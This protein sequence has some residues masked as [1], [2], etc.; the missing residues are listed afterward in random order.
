MSRIFVFFQVCALAVLAF[1]PSVSHAAGQPL[2][3]V[4]PI[5][6]QMATVG[7]AYNY[8]I[9]EDTFS[10][11]YGTYAQEYDA[12]LSPSGDPLPAWLALSLGGTFSGTPQTGDVAVLE[13]EVHA[14]TESCYGQGSGTFTLT[15]SAASGGG[16]SGSS[17]IVTDQSRFRVRKYFGEGV[18]SASGGTTDPVDDGEGD[19]EEPVVGA[20][21]MWGIGG[22]KFGILAIGSPWDDP[23]LGEAAVLTPAVMDGMGSAVFNKVSIGYMQGCGIDGAGA[24][25]CWGANVE[26]ALGLGGDATWYGVPM[27]VVG[28][29]TFA[30]IG[31]ADNSNNACALDTSGVAWCWGSNSYGQLGDGSGAESST[32]VQAQSGATRF[33]KL[34]V[35]TGGTCALDSSGAMWCWGRYGSG[36]TDVPAAYGVG[37]SF[38]DISGHHVHGCGVKTDGSIWCW[39]QNSNGQLGDGGYVDAEN[40]VAVSGG[41]AFASVSVGQDHTCALAAGGV[42]YCWGSNWSNQLGIGDGAVVGYD[43][44]TPAAVLGG[45]S[46]SK[47]V[48]GD[49]R[50]C[51]LKSNGSLW[52]WGDGFASAGEPEAVIMPEGKIFGSV[53]VSSG[54]VNL[55]GNPGAPPSI[56]GTPT[57]ELSISPASVTGMNVVSPAE[58]GSYATFTVENVGA[59]ASP[60][61]ATTLSNTTSFEFG[62]NACSGQTLAIGGTCNMT[63]RPKATTNGGL[64]GTLT[65]SASG[66]AP[67]SATLSGTASGFA[68]A[69]TVVAW[70]YNGDGEL[71]DGTYDNQL[72][73]V[74]MLNVD[75]SA[76]WTGV[77][78]ISDSTAGYVCSR[79]NN[80][81]VWCWGYN[82]AGM[83]GP[84]DIDGYVKPFEMTSFGTVTSL[85]ANGHICAV[86]TDGTVWCL[87]YNDYGEL[88]D[89]TTDFSETAVQVSGLTGASQVV[90]GFYYTCALK[91]DGT[92]WCLGQ[93]DGQGYLGDGSG[94][95]SLVP[96]QVAGEGGVGYLTNVTQI[97]ASAQ[98]TCAVRSDGTVWCWGNSLFGWDLFPV[99]VSGEGGVGFLTGAVEVAAG[100]QHTC[101]RKSDGTVWCWG[102]NES[103]QLGDG[104]VNN[105]ATPVQVLDETGGGVLSNVIAIEARGFNSC[106]VRSDYSVWCWGDNND[107]SLGNGES[108]VSSSLPVRVIGINGAG[109]LEARDVF[110]G[111][112][113]GY[114]LQ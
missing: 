54:V 99:Q 62:A 108:G 57:A 63:V 34:A 74:Q 23:N 102:H 37:H 7:Q 1:C 3:Y 64:S 81:S 18:S 31:V 59:A 70:G 66:I 69:D 103:G 21:T 105:S 95:S 80:G 27:P 47:I 111:W 114:A 72:D 56:G 17:H 9:P 39:G 113:T 88:G 11:E 52:C 48:A 29:H 61:L 87:G 40:P 25:W 15:V 44:S 22:N 112:G 86:R 109:Y 71:N 75:W 97:S 82:D 42:A 36:G 83:L 28:G 110:L 20:G 60:A 96:V 55:V 106:A 49:Q 45:H 58:T 5:P 93:D 38:M 77:A 43:S 101:A 84:D 16:S 10:D 46:F 98:H 107:G 51:A 100:Y 13:I 33:S 67:D 19:D 76:T 89:G 32:P 91:T 6:A 30:S 90:T 50:T 78:A 12:T 4:N 92:V 104:S 24:A 68:S 41:I 79:M 73:P 8:T 26:G 85:S 14:C 94:T 65:V 2:N 35:F 53:D